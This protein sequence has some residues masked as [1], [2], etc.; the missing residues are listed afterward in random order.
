MKR[1]RR[2]PIAI[3]HLGRSSVSTTGY[4]GFK[5]L[6]PND[7]FFYFAC[8]AFLIGIALGAILVSLDNYTLLQYLSYLT[9]TGLES[10]VT[11]NL[12]ATF[13]SC[14]IPHLIMLLLCYLFANC[15]FGMPFIVSLIL[16]QGASAGL[17]GGYIYRYYGLAGM[18]YNFLIT[19][20]PTLIAA[21]G[22]LWLCVYAVKSSITLYGIAVKGLSRK[23][24]E[25]SAQVYHALANATALCC[26]AAF[27][28]AGLFKVFGGFFL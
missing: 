26:L 27:L 11:G 21:I 13:I 17:M 18:L 28:E 14:L 12:F 7:K 4:S 20:P 5:K 15:T 24:K 23:I 16:F 19:M 22:F 1:K 6:D 8:C 10:R 2:K 3:A 25:T 9:K